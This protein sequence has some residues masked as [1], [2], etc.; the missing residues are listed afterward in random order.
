MEDV[1]RRM[2]RTM[3]VF[4]LALI[5][6]FPHQLHAAGAA[7]AAI[8]AGILGILTETKIEQAIYF[9]KTLIDGYNTVKNTYDQ[10][11]RMLEAEKRALNNLRGIADI[12]SFS[13]FMKW[14]NRQLYLARES[15]YQY[16]NLGVK[17]GRQTY[18]I[19]E[20][21]KIPDALRHEFVDRYKN[22]L[23]EQERMDMYVSM[24]LA[25]G[26]YM[27]LKTW[28][29]RNDEI[30]KRIRTYG[31]IFADEHE[32]AAERNQAIASKYTTANEEL[33]I[34][35][36]SKEAHIT[37]MNIEMAVREQTRLMIEM[38]EYQLSRDRMAETPP[39]PPRL[40]EH[41]NKNYFSPVTG[42]SGRDSFE[43]F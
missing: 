12:R 5:T 42:G 31:N 37:Q 18:K 2:K 25:P 13:D 32:E 40:S 35:E 39:S 8:N 9:A 1:M 14:N 22:D 3:T 41:Y 6:A 10:L 16:K 23:T 29:E 43:S 30:A 26:N 38:H 36:I 20:I 19:S 4:V 27:Y 33:D 11:Q 7:A 24:G 34:N 15:E 21:D 17:I 28:Q